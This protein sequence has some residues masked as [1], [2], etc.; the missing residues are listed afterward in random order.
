M[1]KRSHMRGGGNVAFIALLWYLTA[2]KKNIAENFFKSNYR[3]CI[4]TDKLSSQSFLMKFN[5]S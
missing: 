4:C 5:K 1:V 2:K 3:L